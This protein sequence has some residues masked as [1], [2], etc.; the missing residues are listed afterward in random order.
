MTQDQAKASRTLETWAQLRE[1][2]I[3]EKG[4]SEVL[5]NCEILPGAVLLALEFSA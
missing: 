2:A 4:A 1:R 3:P 5:A